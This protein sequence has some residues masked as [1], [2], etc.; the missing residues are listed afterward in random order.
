MRTP[1]K[2]VLSGIFATTL[3]AM[4][5]ISCESAGVGKPQMVAANSRV[6]HAV[7]VR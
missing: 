1:A 3:V 7:N 4:S 2:V 5:A 6:A